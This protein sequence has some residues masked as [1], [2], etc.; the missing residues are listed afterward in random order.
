MAP[1][2]FGSKDWANEL[3]RSGIKELKNEN[4]AKSGRFCEVIAYIHLL[5]EAG[6]W[7]QAAR[8]RNHLY[9]NWESLQPRKADP[10]ESEGV[11]L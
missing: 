6:C 8:L 7:W 4:R 9:R 11:S 1:R 5:L 2:Q 3:L 10:R